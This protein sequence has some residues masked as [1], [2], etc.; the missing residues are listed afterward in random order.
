MPARGIALFG[1]YRSAVEV[2][3][4][5]RCGDYRL[6]IIDDDPANLE[7]ARNAG[8][9]TA[10]LDFR[11]DS[12]LAKLDLG[13]SIDTV[14][15]LFPDDAENVFLTLSARSLAPDIRIYSIAH[16][17]S[18]VPNLHAAGA[19]KVIE[20]EE[21]SGQRIWD[22]IARPIVTAILDQTLF[23]Q[24]NLNVIELKIPKRS[25]FIGKMISQLE[26]ESRY[27]LILLG[28]VDSDLEEHFVYGKTAL[29]THLQAGDILVV[30]GPRDSSTDLRQDLLADNE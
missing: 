18:A 8:Y 29:N 7:K 28:I 15:C 17:K 3:S 4:Y 23:G 25:P 6:V 21:I 1:Y 30:I 20:T 13:E 16:G 10:E 19:D 9:E 2:A 27:N 22:I 24:A 26:F 14:F 12:E 11:D 5:L